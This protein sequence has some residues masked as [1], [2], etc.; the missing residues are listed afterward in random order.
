MRINFVVKYTDESEKIH[1]R[2]ATQSRLN[3]FTSF[4]TK[5]RKHVEQGSIN[6]LLLHFIKLILKLKDEEKP[7]S[8]DS[9]IKRLISTITNNL[10]LYVDNIHIRYEDDL[11]NPLVS[12]A[13]NF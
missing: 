13:N 6:V 7:R 8:H 11:S 2:K 4:L 5:R 3:S 10:Q 9:F 12:H 1:K